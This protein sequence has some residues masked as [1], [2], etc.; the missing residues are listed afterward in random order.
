MKLKLWAAERMLKI[1]KV[2]EPPEVSED[3]LITAVAVIISTRTS[4]IQKKAARILLDHVMGK[5]IVNEIIEEHAVVTDRNDRLVRQWRKKVIAR[6][7]VCK[8]C[9]SEK[10]LHAHHISHWSDDPINR[11]N[12]D[13]GITLCAECH[14]DEHPEMANLILN[15]K[16]AL[17]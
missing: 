11:I 3:D 12:V 13:N 1:Y 7:K 5:K 6:D 10:K 2:Y 17:L 4:P 8:R 9:G 15:R 16:G 14:S